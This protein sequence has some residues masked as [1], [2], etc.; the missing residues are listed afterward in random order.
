VFSLAENEPL[1]FT[2]V[3]S[4]SSSPER[5]NLSR[6]VFTLVW[7]VFYYRNGLAAPSSVSNWSKWLG[8]PLR[9]ASQLFAGVLEQHA[10]LI[11]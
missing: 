4:S 5:T 3:Q 11:V 9:Q 2:E 7:L 6:E 8:S 1:F 10:Y